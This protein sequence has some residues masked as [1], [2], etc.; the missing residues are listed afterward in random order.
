MGVRACGV[1]SVVRHATSS[2]SGRL[3]AASNSASL[4]GVAAPPSLLACH[5][6]TQASSEQTR[7]PSPSAVQLTAADAGTRVSGGRETRHWRAQ[8][9]D[10]ATLGVGEAART[11]C[12]AVR[13]VTAAVV[14]QLP[15]WPSRR[16]APPGVAV[17][18]APPSHRQAGGGRGPGE[19]HDVDDRAVPGQRPLH[20]VQRR[21]YAA[22]LET[23]DGH[24]ACGLVGQH[25]PVV[26][27]RGKGV[28]APR[29][30]G[31]RLPM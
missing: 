13:C 4:E 21:R 1:A 7:R 8:P 24:G 17:H 29:R 12:T 18:P 10:S 9:C 28:Q 6:A 22:R 20:H 23:R 26:L 15:S 3:E 30:R 11:E 27:Q 16:A 5:I 19:G 31:A 2:T 14:Y 25:R